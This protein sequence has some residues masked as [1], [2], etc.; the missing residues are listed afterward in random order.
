MALYVDQIDDISCIEKSGRVIEVTRL[1]RV[2]EFSV[3]T[4]SGSGTGSGADVATTFENILGT[5]GL[6]AAGDSISINSVTLYVQ[7]RD[8]TI[9]EP[10]IA[11][12][13]V[14]FKARER[15][16]ILYN[17]LILRGE[18]SL[19]QIE[20]NLDENSAQ[21]SVT[22]KGKTQGANIQVLVPQAQLTIESTE[23]TIDPQEI[24]MGWIGYLNAEAWKNG[25]ARTWMCTGVSWD[26]TE[27]AFKYLLTYQFQ[28]NIDGWD[29]GVRYVDPETGRPP[30]DLVVG[31]GQKTITWYSERDFSGF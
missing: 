8:V 26:P 4:G 27:T 20:T 17:G 29:I 14:T 3:G 28:Y 22:Y 7:Q 19:S 16:G 6:P 1:Y 5:G 31:T 23:V 12:V 30:H 18:A 21:I 25:A 24:A 13:T 15:R 2:T 10:S 11:E 9:I